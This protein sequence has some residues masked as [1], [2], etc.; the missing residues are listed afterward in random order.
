VLTFSEARAHPHNAARRNSVTV[1]R[2]AQPAPAPRFSRTP[3]A[4]RGAPPERGAGG[5]QALLDW[6]FS[7]PEIAALRQQGLGL[8]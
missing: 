2:V 4:V 3:G 7:E 5:R 8:A 6:G 1:G